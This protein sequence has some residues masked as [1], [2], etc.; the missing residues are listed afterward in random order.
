MLRWVKNSSAAGGVGAMVGGRVAR[1]REFDINDV[2][3]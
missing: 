2:V 1:E 3:V